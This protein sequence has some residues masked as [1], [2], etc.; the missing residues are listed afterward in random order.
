MYGYF[1]TIAYDC[2]NPCSYSILFIG[3]TAGVF[4]NATGGWKGA[5]AGGFVTGI[6]IALGPALLYPVMEL[7]GL[8]G[9]TFPETDFVALGL[10]IYYLGKMFGR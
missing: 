6:L 4:G 2:N 5:I 8:S 1:S 7:I 9:T 10:V 3:A